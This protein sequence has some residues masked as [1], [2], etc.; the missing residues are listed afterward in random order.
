MFLLLSKVFSFLRKNYFNK[1]LIWICGKRYKN[2]HFF[3]RGCLYG[4][5]LAWLTGLAFLAG[6]TLFLRKPNKLMYVHMRSEPTPLSRVCLN[7][8]GPEHISPI[9]REHV[10]NYFSSVRWDEKFYMNTGQKIANQYEHPI[11]LRLIF[12]YVFV[13]FISVVYIRTQLILTWQILT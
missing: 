13:I 11:S 3:L 4:G 5:E 12:I 1:W 9:R 6:I 7:L 8:P 10:N 2:L